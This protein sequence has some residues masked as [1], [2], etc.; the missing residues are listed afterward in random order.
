LG[1]VSGNQDVN[2][3]LVLGQLLEYLGRK[4]GAPVRDK[5]LQLGWEQYAQGF[6]HRFSSDM[7]AGHKERETQ[8]LPGAVVGNEQD[9]NPGGNHSGSLQPLS[10]F[11]SSLPPLLIFLFSLRQ[12]LASPLP[13][14][15]P[16]LVP[17]FLAAMRQLDARISLGLSSFL[18]PAPFRSPTLP[19]AV[20]L[21]T[22]FPHLTSFDFQFFFSP[23]QS[24]FFYFCSYSFRCF[25]A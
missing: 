20:F 3:L 15:P 24:C 18:L 2:K 11:A 5:E 19:C 22:M 17:D 6:N 14:V 13:F 25:R 1:P 8:T 9:G 4:M 7:S 16:S 23:A 10:Y 21:R 12:L